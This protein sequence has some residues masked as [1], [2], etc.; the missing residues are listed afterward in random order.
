MKESKKIVVLQSENKK[1]PKKAQAPNKKVENV[2]KEITPEQEEKALEG[3]PHIDINSSTTEKEIMCPPIDEKLLTEPKQLKVF[4]PREN[5]LKEK[6]NKLNYD[7]KLLNNIQKD[8][9]SQIEEIKTQIK[10]NNILITQVPKDLNKYIIRSASSDTKIVKYSNEDYELKKKH[11][12]IKELKEEET[13]L[14]QKLLKIEENEALLNNEGF[15]S[16]NKSYEGITKLDKSI[17]EQHIKTIKNKKNDINERLK[18]I[19]FRIDLLL[20]EDNSK[21]TKREKL[22]NFKDTFERDKEIIEARANK[23]LKETKERN[24]RLANDINQ[25][26]EKRKKE[27][28]KKEKDEQLKKEKIR[29]E[30]IE[31]EKAIEQKRLKEKEVIMLKYKPF[32]NVKNEKT[33]KD[34]LFGIYDKRYQ[35]KEQKLIE[36]IN[37]ERKLKSRTVTSEELQNFLTKVEEKKEQLKKEKE[38]KNKEELAKFEMAKNYKPSYISQFNENAN[39]EYIKIREKEQIRRDEILALKSMKEDYSKNVRKNQPAINENLKKKR[40]DKILA[41]ENPKLLQIKDTLLK[42]K[43]KE[44][45]KNKKK[46]DDSWM[47]KLFRLED[48]NDNIDNLNNSAI[49]QNN[50]IKKPKKI[51]FYSAKKNEKEDEKKKK[52]KIKI[53][54]Q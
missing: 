4:R 43:K 30:F 15:I 52:I 35:E 26:A 48:K 47:D 40:M 13:A 51:R 23:Y 39:E 53:K 19:E 18:E 34:Y 37:Y 32:I 27:I 21:L 49:I 44:D 24:K 41:L 3:Q 29:K 17:K 20:K 33:E 7:S 50:L 16:L 10:D 6:I 28:E 38:I 14:K 22:Q 42:R 11:K 1:P 31:K 5:Y 54:I 9:G 8:L 45:E 12:V 46:S 36:K 2:E 25:L